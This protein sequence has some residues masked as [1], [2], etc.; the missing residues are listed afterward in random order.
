MKSENKSK[1][2]KRSA[3]QRVGSANE[4]IVTGQNSPENYNKRRREQ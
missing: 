2:E 4:R 3:G 1:Q